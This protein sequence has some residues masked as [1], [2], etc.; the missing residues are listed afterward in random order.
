MTEGFALCIYPY[1]LCHSYDYLHYTETDTYILRKMKI[2]M[3]L[4]FPFWIT[5]L[6]LLGNIAYITIVHEC[7]EEKKKIGYYGFVNDEASTEYDVLTL[8]KKEKACESKQPELNV[9]MI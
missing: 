1:L 9:L 6:S 7:G 3:C 5:Q 4:M 2:S 8:S